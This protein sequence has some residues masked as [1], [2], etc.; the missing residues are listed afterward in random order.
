MKGLVG[1]NRC[2]NLVIKQQGKTVYLDLMHYSFL[3]FCLSAGNLM[4][5]V[6]VTS[7][8]LF[9]SPTFS[10]CGAAMEGAGAWDRTG[11]RNR[12][13]ISG[14]K[15]IIG[16]SEHIRTN[17]SSCWGIFSLLCLKLNTFQLCLIPDLFAL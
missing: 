8:G 3:S 15:G 7:K 10:C 17:L 13:R 5:M 12:V 1:T 9:W 11:L 6:R 14:H 2:I 4:Q 16:R